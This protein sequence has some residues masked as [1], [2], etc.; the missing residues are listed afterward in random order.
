MRELIFMGR[1]R[2]DR[3]DGHTNAIGNKMHSESRRYDVGRNNPEWILQRFESERLTRFL[4]GCRKINYSL[5]W[6][7]FLGV[8]SVAGWSCMDAELGDGHA[9]FE[10]L[11]WYGVI[12]DST[13]VDV[14][15]SSLLVVTPLWRR[16][17]P[18]ALSSSLGM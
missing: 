17:C 18:R 7:E 12:T 14:L 6:I 15:N 10:D 11:S 4:G 8:L 9:Q 5:A 16:R 3:S 2:S 1:R 13:T